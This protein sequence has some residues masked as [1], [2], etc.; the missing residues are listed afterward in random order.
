MSLESIKLHAVTPVGIS[1]CS[2]FVGANLC[3]SNVTIPTL[4]LPRPESGSNTS[5]KNQGQQ[6]SLAESPVATD[7]HLARQWQHIYTIGSR[8]GPVLALG[9]FAAFSLA[10][11]RLPSNELGRHVLMWTAAASSLAIAPFTFTFMLKTNTELHRRADAAS[12]GEDIKAKA[13]TTDLKSRS[14]GDLLKW[15]AK[16][17]LM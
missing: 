7:A 3:I 16:L 2:V 13:P 8:A 14:T 4:L 12:A 1:L 5:S 9:A 15:W 10:S 6:A 17:N 11:T